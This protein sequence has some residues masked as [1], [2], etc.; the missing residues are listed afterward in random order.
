MIIFLLSL[1]VAHF[2]RKSLLNYCCRHSCASLPID[3]SPVPAAVLDIFT[4][5]KCLHVRV[6]DS[7]DELENRVWVVGENASAS[8]IANI[9][10]SHIDGLWRASCCEGYYM[11]DSN[12]GRYLRITISCANETVAPRTHVKYLHDVY[13]YKFTSTCNL[14]LFALSHTVTCLVKLLCCVEVKGER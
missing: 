13:A 3:T 7:I 11:K 4:Q 12:V 10:D 8:F 2:C 9:R 6:G 1:I 5:Q 14:S